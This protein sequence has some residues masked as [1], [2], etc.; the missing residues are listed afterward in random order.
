MFPDKMYNVDHQSEVGCYQG[1]GEP[2]RLRKEVLK[3]TVHV[4]LSKVKWLSLSLS[5]TMMFLF[6]K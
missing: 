6:A 3:A 5:L 1:N 4:M 2:E